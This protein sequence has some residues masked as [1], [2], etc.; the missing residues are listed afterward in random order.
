MCMLNAL[1]LR[2]ESGTRIRALALVC[3]DAILRRRRMCEDVAPL[4][5]RGTATLTPSYVASVPEELLMA[6]VLRSVIYL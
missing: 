1:S 6:D 3:A 4:V 2:G 5:R